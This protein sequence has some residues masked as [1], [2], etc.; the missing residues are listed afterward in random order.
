MKYLPGE[1]A[2]ADQYGSA[3]SVVTAPFSPHAKASFSHPFFSFLDK[4][5][6]GNDWER[7][8]ILQCIFLNDR[9]EV[10][11]YSYKRKKGS[12]LYWPNTY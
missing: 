12:R 7:N 9:N 10:N 8:I 5:M 2:T 4:E 6:K 3:R 11:Y 1:G